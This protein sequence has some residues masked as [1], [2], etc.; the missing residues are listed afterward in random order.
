MATIGQGGLGFSGTV[1]FPPGTYPA[2][3]GGMGTIILPT[4][5]NRPPVDAD[6]YLPIDG[7]MVYDR[8][9]CKLYIRA[10]NG[11]WPSIGLA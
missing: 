5:D 10:L 1:P 2:G 4:T 9:T 8:T 3:T 7:M 6:F 11:S